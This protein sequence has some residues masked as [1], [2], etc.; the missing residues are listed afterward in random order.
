MV[1]TMNFVG[2]HL[3]LL[4]ECMV[5]LL[6]KSGQLSSIRSKLHVHMIDDK[7]HVRTYIFTSTFCWIM[8]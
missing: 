1:C 8:L 2:T 3:K 7:N 5:K 4:L 6:K